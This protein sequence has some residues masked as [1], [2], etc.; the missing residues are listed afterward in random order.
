[1]AFFPDKVTVNRPSNNN[2]YL[3]INFS[4]T[5]LKVSSLKSSEKKKNVRILL[6]EDGSSFR[7]GWRTVVRV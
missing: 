6:F 2:E 7:V 5:K 3:Q 4:E 1:M